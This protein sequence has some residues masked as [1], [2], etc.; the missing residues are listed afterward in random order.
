M[1][2]VLRRLS[3]LCREICGSG[4]KFGSFALND[5]S[6]HRGDGLANQSEVRWS[7]IKE[8]IRAAAMVVCVWGG[9]TGLFQTLTNVVKGQM[10]PWGGEPLPP[11]SVRLRH[12]P[13]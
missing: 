1:A 13:W 2:G 12:F 6:G 11:S 7:P 5:R 10:L 9:E 4:L 3:R 8:M